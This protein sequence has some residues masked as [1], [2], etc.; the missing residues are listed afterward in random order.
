MPRGGGGGA[1]GDRVDGEAH[2][3]E[4]ERP[5]RRRRR[6]PRAL[7]RRAEPAAELC[8][9]RHPAPEREQQADERLEDEGQHDVGEEVEDG[10]HRRRDAAGAR[11]Q[12]AGGDA[13][14]D[15]DQEQEERAP[16]TGRPGCR[17]VEQRM[18]EVCGHRGPE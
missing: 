9:D 10:H 17:R 4:A 12:H 13:A 2:E 5:A 16:G 6:A 15:G 11:E 18:H 3:H 1:A 8:Q 7:E 14:A